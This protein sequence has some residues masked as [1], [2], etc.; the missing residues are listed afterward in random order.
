MSGGH[1]DYKDRQIEYLI[2]ELEDLDLESLDNIEDKERFQEVLTYTK[3][4]LKIGFI[5]AHRI[6]ALVS[7][8]HGEESFYQRLKEDLDN[9]KG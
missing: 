5:Y 4:I 9:L 1:F 3:K 2:Q 8:D 6:D 7:G